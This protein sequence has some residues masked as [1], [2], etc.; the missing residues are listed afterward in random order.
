VWATI[1]STEEA[2]EAAQRG[3]AALVVQGAEAG[4][5]VR[6]RLG[7]G[8]LLPAVR[9]VVGDVPIVAAGGIADGRGV[10]ASLA[11]GADAVCLGTRLVASVECT[12][13]EDYKA[14]IVATN[15]NDTSITTL[16]GP[17]WPDAPMRVIRNRA[18]EEGGPTR[19]GVSI[20]ETTV[21]GQR[22]VLPHHSAL[23]PT[24]ET[25]GDIEGMCLAAGV[26]VEF[27]HDVVPAAGIVCSI[28]SEAAACLMRC[29]SEISTS[30]SE[31]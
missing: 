25:K 9:D 19:P 11:L 23:L 5:H 31:P 18:V 4:G 27:V 8:T 12:A 7:L 14:R 29:A 15:A 20:G 22:Y 1:T 26:S 28:M 17:E 10:A 24:R 30:E 3:S 2:V 21:F 6:A 13:R 16:F